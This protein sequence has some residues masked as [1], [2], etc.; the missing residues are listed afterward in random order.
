MGQSQTA[1]AQLKNAGPAEATFRVI[2]ADGVRVDPDRGRILAGDVAGLDVT[3]LL[4]RQGNFAAVVE[5]EQRGGKT[6]RLP[7]RWDYRAHLT[8]LQSHARIIR[9]AVYQ[10]SL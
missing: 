9:K 5:V 3:L 4:T 2:R 8:G 10:Q 6:I 7:I 1:T